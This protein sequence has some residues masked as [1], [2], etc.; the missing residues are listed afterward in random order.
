MKNIFRIFAAMTATVAFAA[1]DLTLLPEDKV[2]PDTYFKT[3]TDMERWTN[4]YYTLIVNPETSTRYNADD[5][6]DK[7]MGSIIEGTRMASDDMDG[8]LE[9]GWKPLR[10]INY[11]LENSKNCED[12]AVKDKYDG[13]SYFF[14]AYFYYQKVLRFGDVPWYDTVLASDDNAALT[15]PRDDRGYVID[16]VIQDL[17]RAINRLPSDRGTTVDGMSRVNKWTAV[18]LK[19]RVAL[20]EGTWRK[21]RGMENADKYLQAAAEAARTFIDESGYSLYKG[22]DTPYR[23]LFN[24]DDISEVACEVILAR[25]YDATTLKIGHSVQFNIKNDAQGFTRRFMNHY[26][27]VTGERFTEQPGNETMF[28]T[29]EVQNRDPRLA[30]TVLCPGYIQKGGKDVIANDMN[31]HTGYQPIKYIAQ[32]AYDGASKG[33]TSLPLF[34]AAEVYLVY[35]EALAELGTLTQADLDISVNKIRDRVSMPKLDMATANANP[36]PFLA[37]CYPNVTQSANTGVILEIRRERTV[38]LVNEGFRQWDML[39]WK[40]GAQMVNTSTDASKDMRY[41]GVYFP[42]P[43]LYDMDGDGANDFQLYEK[44]TTPEVG[45]NSKILG[46]DIILSEGTSG[47]VV[48]H[49]EMTYSFDETRDYLWPIPADQRVLSGGNLTQNPGWTDSTNYN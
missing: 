24:R 6:V 47:Y 12:Q 42:G 37:G 27:M 35:A 21:Y 31:S 15:K 32:E 10:W 28:Y 19:A 17:D 29:D 39:R 49:P 33:S 45:M 18:A 7:S 14:R 13:V 1:C 26:L 16:M 9:W 22:G 11:H 25:L 5:M 40:E 44:G 8:S 38:E 41:F 48:A 46:V 4:R 34:R 3:Q 43:G 36:D 30:Q 23:D 2:S 20:F